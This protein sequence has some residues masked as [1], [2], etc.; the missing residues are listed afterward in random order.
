MCSLSN[1]IT[2]PTVNVDTI[3]SKISDDSL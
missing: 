1:E 2:H 3:R